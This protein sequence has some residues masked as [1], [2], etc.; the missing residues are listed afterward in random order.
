MVVNL[1][2]VKGSRSTGP[3]QRSFPSTI[4]DTHG[5]RGCHSLDV[6]PLDESR[7]PVKAATGITS[8]LTSTDLLL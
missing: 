4:T 5:Y 2:S 8:L 3:R 1:P 7:V 6:S